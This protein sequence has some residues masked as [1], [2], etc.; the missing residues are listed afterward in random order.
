MFAMRG[1]Q[2]SPQGNG[3]VIEPVQ[4]LRNV[5]ACRVLRFFKEEVRRRGFDAAIGKVQVEQVQQETEVFAAR[6]AVEQLEGADGGQDFDVG[7][8]RNAQ[9][10]ADLVFM[11]HQ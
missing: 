5:R 7:F 6:I 3:V 2:Y 10:N 11:T 9:G 8:P 4:R 1:L